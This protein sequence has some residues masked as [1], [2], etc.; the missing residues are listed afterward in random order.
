MRPEDA[1]AKGTTVAARERVGWLKLAASLILA[2]A[3]FWFLFKRLDVTSVLATIQAMTWLELASIALVAF[4]NLVAH[5]ALWVAVT[6][7]LSWPRAAIVAQSGTAV[8]NT[9]PGG[10]GI[11]I[12]LIYSMLDSWG[13]PRGRSTSKSTTT[14]AASSSLVR[15]RNFIV[16]SSHPVTGGRLTR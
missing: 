16:A 13:F 1:R 8:T 5:W 2:V 6:P 12:G 7:G 11:G 4:W 14:A 10:S 3:I 15:R 9:I